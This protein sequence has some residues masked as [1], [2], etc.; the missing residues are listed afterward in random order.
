MVVPL[1]TH[2]CESLQL[3]VATRVQVHC[4]D[5]KLSNPEV[6]SIG[7]ATAQVST[8]AH[9]A[10]DCDASTVPSV[11]CAILPAGSDRSNTTVDIADSV[12]AAVT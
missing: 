1:V 11:D 2:S 10:D 6:H 5:L 9:A 7:A 8:A 4:R 12:E 3:S